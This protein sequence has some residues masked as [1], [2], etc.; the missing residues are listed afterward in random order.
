MAPIASSRVKSKSGVKPLTVSRPELLTN[1][2]DSQFRVF[3]HGMLAFAAR[4]E[5]V[6]DGFAALFGLTGIQYTL[7]IS[8]SHLNSEGE[9]T[10]GA[11]ADHLHLSGAFLTT[12]T[13]KLLRSGLIAKVQDLKDRRRVRLSVT[14]KGF[15]LLSELAP[16][17]VPVNEVLFEFLSTEQFRA[18]GPMVD[19]I[20]ACGDRAISLLDYL[21]TNS[22]RPAQLSGSTALD[23]KRKSRSRR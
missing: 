11:V 6:R 2:S 14:P 18:I 23:A 8:I 13:G 19:R 20:V 21:S 15:E 10:V 7:F 22:A 4:L 17:Q 16:V 5:A 3:V 1:G 9:V 12:E